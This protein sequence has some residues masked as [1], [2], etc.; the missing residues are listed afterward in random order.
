MWMA[1]VYMCGL[2]RLLRATVTA[3]G[4]LRMFMIMR[5]M[6]EMG[7]VPRRNS[8]TG[9]NAFQYIT[10]IRQGRVGSIERQHN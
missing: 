3:V 4:C 8:I 2:R 1:M 6:T 5:V 10:H 9:C 7:V